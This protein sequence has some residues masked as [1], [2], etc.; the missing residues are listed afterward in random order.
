MHYTRIITPGAFHRSTRS[1]R[2]AVALTAET[3]SALVLISIENR[4]GVPD[5]VDADPVAKA[6]GLP[7]RLT[8]LRWIA[9]TI[10][11]A[12]GSGWFNVE[13]FDTW[14]VDLILLGVSI[15]SRHWNE[16]FN[17]GVYNAHDA[18][19]GRLHRTVIH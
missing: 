5:T 1:F 15:H 7:D 10:G 11:F 19:A 12:T 2:K 8:R 17:Q 9:H 14:I 6:D 16:A 13:F 3:E 4:F 18:A